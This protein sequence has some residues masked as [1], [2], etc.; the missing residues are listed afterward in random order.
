MHRATIKGFRPFGV[1]VE[2]QGYRR[3]GMVH[4]SQLSNHM[5]SSR[6]DSDE[7]K[8]EAMKGVVSEGEQVWVKV[9]EV[10]EDDN[11]GRTRIGCSVKLAN[12]RDGTDL[13]PHGINYQPRPEGGGGGRAPVGA[14]A[15]ETAKG[16]IEWVRA[17]PPCVPLSQLGRH[18]GVECRTQSVRCDMKQHY[19]RVWA[20]DT[21][22]RHHLFERAW[23]AAEL[24][25]FQY[26]C[27][28]AVSHLAACAHGA[29]TPCG[30][31]EA[32]GWQQQVRS[33][34]VG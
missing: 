17:F 16:K 15:G 12:Q 7:Q 11:T 26:T 27:A 3:W 23:K 24:S 22:R 21:D 25:V 33:G 10:R 34:G 28:A 4:L 20:I 8:V 31:R 19:T 9:V 13:D 29:G 18:G 5:E 32:D 2:L 6:D 1:F 30:R 14:Q